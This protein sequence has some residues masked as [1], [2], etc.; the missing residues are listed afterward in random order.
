M[1]STHQECG[2]VQDMKTQK[3][4]VFVFKMG[5]MNHHL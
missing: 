3:E 1:M 2:C 4:D 5:T